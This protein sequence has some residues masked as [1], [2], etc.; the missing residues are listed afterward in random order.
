[1]LARVTLILTLLEMA[2]M[3]KEAFTSRGAYVTDGNQIYINGIAQNGVKF[4][5]W[6]NSETKQLKSF[7][8]VKDWQYDY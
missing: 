6:I 4:E 3:A 1:M 5:G 2:S 8:P 7:Y